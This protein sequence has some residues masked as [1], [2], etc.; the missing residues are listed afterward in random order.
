MRKYLCGENIPIPPPVSVEEAYQLPVIDPMKKD[1]PPLTIYDMNN[2]PR[3]AKLYTEGEEPISCP[4]CTDFICELETVIALPM[5]G[6]TFHEGCV[7]P[8]FELRGSCPLD[9]SDIREALNI[10]RTK[11]IQA[12]LQCCIVKT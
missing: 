3:T 8:W 12:R 6:H 9:R 7:I 2:L 5:C 1:V 11:E 10:L 4:I